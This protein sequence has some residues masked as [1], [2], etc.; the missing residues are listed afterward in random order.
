[1][2]IKESQLYSTLW[3]ACDSLRGGM[4]ASRV[5][6]RRE[7]LP[8]RPALPLAS[9]G[10]TTLR[11]YYQQAKRLAGY[12]SLAR[13][14]SGEPRQCHER[15]AS[16]RTKGCARCNGRIMDRK[17]RGRKCGAGSKADEHTMGQLHREETSPHLQP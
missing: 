16:G 1:M 8:L 12:D 14:N 9:S 4:D 15:M 2:A 13:Y 6:Q 7:F 17:S 10:T 3:N 5:R 11:P